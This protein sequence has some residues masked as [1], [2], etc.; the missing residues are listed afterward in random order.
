MS[1]KSNIYPRLTA[2]FTSTQNAKPSF[3]KP[4][5]KPEKIK[6]KSPEVLPKTL[7]N[8]IKELLQEKDPHILVEKFQHLSQYSVF[9]ER[10]REIYKLTVHRLAIAKQTSLIEQLLD[11]Q[12]MYMVTE[13]FGSR[14]IHLYGKYGM[15]DHAR[16]V[17]DEMPERKCTRGAKS[18]NVLLGAAAN[19]GEY[20]KVYELFREWP[21]KM[22]IELNVDCY[23][24]AMRAFCST[25][26]VEEAVLLLDEM[27]E[28]EL[29]PCVISFNT[30]LCVYYED[31]EVEKGDELWERMV[32]SGVVPNT[33]S[34][35][36]KL[37][38]LINDGKLLEAIELAKQLKDMG[39]KP[40]ECTFD[41]VIEG[42]VKDD[43]LDC[44]KEW[45]GKLLNSGCLPNKATFGTLA[46][47]LCQKG[48]HGLAFELC[49]K[50]LKGRN[51]SVDEAVLQSV[52]DCLAENSMTDK[53]KVLVELGLSN[54][55]A[56]YH[57][58]M[59]NHV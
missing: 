22:S 40:D 11:S 26:R 56:P 42:L 1:S 21:K 5:K 31:G 24:T 13:G 16:K 46:P 37:R 17:F 36:F 34:Y 54:S 9:R 14:I 10:C 52:V 39:V 30:L 45:Y 6:P 57:L 43:D 12:K 41:A 20:E 48:E 18:F 59:P 58:I 55:Y 49:E 2:L 53:A 35:N 28:N 23:N 27:E 15:F 19:S 50:M 32:K 44:A 33:Q 51:C 47:F 7:N 25:G 8:K 38:G 3:I 29:K 4:S